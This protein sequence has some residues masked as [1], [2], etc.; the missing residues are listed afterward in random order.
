MTPGDQSIT[1]ALDYLFSVYDASNKGSL[2]RKEALQFFKELF[3]Y[4]QVYPSQESLE[5]LF[6][7]VDFDG[8][9]HITKQ[10]LYKIVKT[11][12]YF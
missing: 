5:H 3:N 9:D 4:N 8:D 7:I 6:D 1:S 11:S 12:K 2:N 10:E